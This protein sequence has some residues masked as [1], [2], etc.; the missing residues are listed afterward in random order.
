MEAITTFARGS[1]R[2]GVSELQSS[3][4]GISKF[5]YT[6][7][8]FPVVPSNPGSNHKF[9]RLCAV[10]GASEVQ[11]TSRGTFV[12]PQ[13][14]FPTEE[15]V[16]TSGRSP[17]KEVSGSRALYFLTLT[18][19]Q[20]DDADI[21]EPNVGI[22]VSLIG[23]NGN[24]ILK[25]V[26]PVD[27]ANPSRFQTRF[28][29]GSN[30]NDVFVATD[31]DR[32]AALWIAPEKGT[33]KP[34]QTRVIILQWNKE[35]DKIDKGSRRDLNTLLELMSNILAQTTTSRK[36]KGFVYLFDS[37]EKRL[38]EADESLA[39]ELRPSFVREFSDP[40]SM[41]EALLGSSIRSGRTPSSS[42]LSRDEIERLRAS[43]MKDYEA[44]KL[45]FL[46]ISSLLVG[47]G[48]AGFAFLG[49]D[50]LTESFAAG[51]LGGFLYLLLLQRFVDQLPG[52]DSA[53]TEEEQGT[54]QAGE[55]TGFPGNARLPVSI[56]LVAGIAVL[57][58]RISNG[59]AVS[60]I[61]PQMLIAGIAGFLTSR[62]A[63]IIASLRAKS[64]SDNDQQ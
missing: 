26:P 31:V 42:Y 19:S 21:S 8:C 24:A 49:E 13:R 20:D 28:Q 30:D 54:K 51:G 6:E 25:T 55:P 4:K 50:R 37:N 27:I 10:A 53:R 59:G 46:G 14:L 38:G 48:T 47:V 1:I 39:A 58:G 29:A 3:R 23:E 43:S 62:A 5:R 44:L 17:E 61:T 34:A 9:L 41:R 56:A 63:V 33:W 52:P 11:E 18:T 35:F 40:A 2:L 15:D 60:S 32:L 64:S 36:W 12:Q 22:M 45:Q 16:S 7:I 57:V